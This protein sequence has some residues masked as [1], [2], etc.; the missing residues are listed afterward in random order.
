[1]HVSEANEQSDLSYV[2]KSIT[3]YPV[4][5]AVVKHDQNS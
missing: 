4:V 3:D 2:A 5:R 1:M